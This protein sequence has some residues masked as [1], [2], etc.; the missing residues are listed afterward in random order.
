MDL[1]LMAEDWVIERKWKEAGSR[2][3]INVNGE[4]MDIKQASDLLMERLNIPL[5]HYPQGS[6]YGRRAWPEL[7]WRSLL[8][9][10][11]RRQALWT[12]LADSQPDSEQHACLMQFFGIAEYL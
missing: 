4:M 6:L 2:T 3:K 9:H 7:G 10:V 12:D 11:Y 5:V 8:R 1:R